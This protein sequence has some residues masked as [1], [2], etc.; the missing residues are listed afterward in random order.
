[1]VIN[2]LTIQQIA[3]GAG[4]VKA[5]QWRSQITILFVALFAAWQV[6]GEIPDNDAP[7][8]ASNTKIAAAQAQTE[9]LLRKRLLENL[10]A[11]NANPPQ[12]ELERVKHA[13]TDRSLR[14]HYD[15]VLEFSVALRILSAR[16]ISPN[17]I[18]RGCKAL[19]RAVQSWARMNCH[20]TPYFHFSQHFEDQY[21][22]AGPAPGWWAYGYERNNGFLGQTNH[23]N[24]KGGELE[25]TMMRKWYKMVFIQDL[26][27]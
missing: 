21:L 9:T 7:S 2:Q 11:K 4:T 22:R 20:L 5:D 1:M 27:N 6:D 13:K 26:V 16:S 24:H 18:K 12:E 10:L 17:E 14:R 25:A 15:A 19:S 3:R 8:S 23:N